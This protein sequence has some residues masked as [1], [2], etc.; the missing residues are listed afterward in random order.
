MMLNASTLLSEGSHFHPPASVAAPIP[1]QAVARRPLTRVE[2]LP[3]PRPSKRLS[4]KTC[5]GKCC[6]GRCRF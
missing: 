2:A 6:I 4:C 5:L 1:L 3:Q